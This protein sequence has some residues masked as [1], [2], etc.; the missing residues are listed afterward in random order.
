MK[1]EES[2]QV[3]TEADIERGLRETLEEVGMTF[4]ELKEQA[5]LDRF[6]DFRAQCAWFVVS[7]LDPDA[8]AW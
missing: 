5:R 3:L 7:F 4:E 6:T 8:A 2:Y 1:Q